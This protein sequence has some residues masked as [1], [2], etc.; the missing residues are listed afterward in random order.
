[1]IDVIDV[2]YALNNTLFQVDVLFERRI[3]D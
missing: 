1:L 2:H 3:N